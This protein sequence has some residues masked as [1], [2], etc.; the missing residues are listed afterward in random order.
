MVQS[1]APIFVELGIVGPDV[2]EI[3]SELISLVCISALSAAIGSKT[4]GESLKTINYGRFLVILLYLVSWAFAVTS[5]VVVS[6]NNNNIISCTLGMLSC[7]IFYA[8]SKIIIYAW[9][10]E[11]I[12]LVT[13]VKTSRFKTCQYK[14]HIGLLCPYIIIFVLMLTY[15]NIYLESDGKCTIG[16]QLVASVPLLVYDF[17]LNLYLT[18]LFMAP[19]MNVGLS[20]KVNWKRSK[21]YRVARHTLVASIVS[22]LISF[23]NVLVVV[24]THGHERGLVCLTMC[25][26]DV[27]INAVTVYWVTTNRRTNKTKNTSGRGNKPFR[28]SEDRISAELTFDAQEPQNHDNISKYEFASIHLD[29]DSKLNMN[30]DDSGESVRSIQI[31]QLSAKPLHR[32]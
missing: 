6:T 21:L 25:T 11:R 22:L 15:R 18:W 23:V 26:L 27:T 20:S 4:F 1:S 13:A 29:R 28:E 14:A 5:V 32:Y 12:H 17:I 30:E 19:L 7:D 8:G 2:L 10:I 16:L 3:I 31:S 9:L 24:I